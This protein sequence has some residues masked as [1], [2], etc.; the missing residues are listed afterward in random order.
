MHASDFTFPPFLGF[1]YFVSNISHKVRVNNKH[2]D[3]TNDWRVTLRD[4]SKEID[5]FYIT[6]N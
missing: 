2:R 3:S 5:I 6:N 1:Q 4:L